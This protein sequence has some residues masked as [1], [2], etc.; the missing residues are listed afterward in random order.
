[1]L[2]GVILR[3]GKFAR[4]VDVSPAGGRRGAGGLA[5]RARASRGGSKLPSAIFLLRRRSSQFLF[6]RLASGC[7]S[8]R[9]DRRIGA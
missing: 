9:V 2:A 7:F 4:L 5:S 8:M 1:M 3:R 6:M